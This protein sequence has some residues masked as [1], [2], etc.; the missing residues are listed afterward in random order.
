MDHGTILAIVGIGLTIVLAIIG[1]LGKHEFNKLNTKIDRRF[2]K[3]NI[4]IEGV[5]IRLNGELSQINSEIK[6]HREA[7]TMKIE[8]LNNRIKDLENLIRYSKVSSAPKEKKRKKGRYG[9][10]T[11]S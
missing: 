1:T 11:S 10:N 2:D 8:A 6:L 4:K 9:D 5:E 3:F 7:N